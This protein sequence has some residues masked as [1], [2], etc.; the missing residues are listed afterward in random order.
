MILKQGLDAK[1]SK[2]MLGFEHLLFGPGPWR[3]PL[4]NYKR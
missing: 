1:R 4:A 2:R 3:L